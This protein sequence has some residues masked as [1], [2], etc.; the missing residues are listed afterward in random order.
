MTQD[1]EFE[2][3]IQSE[4]ELSKLYADTHEIELPDHLDAAI[5][6]EAHRAVDARPGAKVRRRWT[7]PLGMVA[8]LFVAVMIGMQLPYMLPEAGKAP[9]YKKEEAVQSMSDSTASAASERKKTFAMDTLSA[10]DTSRKSAAGRSEHLREEPAMMSLEKEPASKAYAPPLPST[11]VL[12]QA[13]AS[14]TQPSQLRESKSI[15]N[16]LSLS[17]AKESL[18]P[19]SMNVGDSLESPAPLVTMTAPAPE[20]LKVG[21]SKLDEADVSNL[22]AEDWLKRIKK[23]KQAGKQEEAKKDLT[24]F[25]KNFPTYAIPKELDLP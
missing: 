14:V 4:A 25:K 13:P 21:P 12:P 6:A 17:K 16:G 7:I 24:A 20:Q 2:Q 18:V 23:L 9:Q 15:N 10:K 19:R 5:L 1:V 11:V 22:S 3:Y 8:T